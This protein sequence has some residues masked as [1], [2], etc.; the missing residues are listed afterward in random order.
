MKFESRA[1]GWRASLRP[2]VGRQSAPF[3]EG[4]RRLVLKPSGAG[5]TGWKESRLCFPKGSRYIESMT[6]E[7]M[8]V[9]TL[10]E[11]KRIELRVGEILAAEPVPGTDRLL[12]L[13]VDLGQER[14]TVVAGLA[15]SFSQDELRGMKVVMVA[16]LAPIRIRGIE[17]Q[18]MLLGVGC[19]EVKSMALLTVNRPMPNGMLVV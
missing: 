7:V 2:L 10:E 12:K 16:N 1:G 8:A 5:K 4:T 13:A 18:G 19:E 11:F 17:S 3:W 14:R 15:Q 9:I 6:K